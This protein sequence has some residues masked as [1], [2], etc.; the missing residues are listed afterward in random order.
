MDHQR[1]DRDD[2]GHE[3]VTQYPD[4]QPGGTGEEDSGKPGQYGYRDPDAYP[5]DQPGGSGEG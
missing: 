5:E 3:D 4:K 2:D 1:S